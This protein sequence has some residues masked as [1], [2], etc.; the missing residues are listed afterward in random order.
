MRATRESDLAACAA[1]VER[2]FDAVESE[3]V[4]VRQTLVALFS[5]GPVTAAAASAAIEDRVRRHLRT[6]PIIGAGYVAA[7]GAL[8]DRSLYLAWWQG[9]DETLLA[10]HTPSHGSDFDYTRNEWFRTPSMSRHPHVT[11]PYVDFV[12]SDEYVMTHTVPVIVD[13]EMLGVVG[14]DTLVETLEDLFLD[15][16]RSARATLVNS[17][18]R[19]IVSADPHV[20]TGDLIEAD[21]AVD[22]LACTRLPLR[23][24]GLDGAR[25][26]AA[27]A[28]TSR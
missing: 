13:G 12:C 2:Y 22:H 18:G 9:Q 6:S 26:V 17:H 10:D 3:L 14:A 21:A 19:A 27:P 4:A 1:T 5:H 15:E 16:F 7:P 23:L 8:A 11:G 24:I 28:Q 20:A 25:Q